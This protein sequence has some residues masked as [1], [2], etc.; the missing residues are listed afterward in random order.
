VLLFGQSRVFYAMA[1]DRLLPKFFAAVHPAWRTPYRSHLF[2]MVFAC[3]LGG[4][5]PISQLGHMTSIGT[6]LAF[7]I[8]CAGVIIMRRTHP[9][10]ERGYRTPAVPVVPVA[11]ILVCLAMMVSL[12]GETWL[13]LVV[14]LAI[15][16][17]IYFGYSRRHSR[18]G[19]DEA[20]AASGARAD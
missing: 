16:L 12:D 20:R 19:R 17:V 8:V 11:G 10:Q 13:R 1:Q 3:L 5:L 14:W 4:F 15:G 7:I 9:H 6:L 2:F 18:V